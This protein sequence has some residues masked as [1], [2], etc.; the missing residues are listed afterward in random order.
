VST[1]VSV[2]APP[3]FVRCHLLRGGPSDRAV[4]LSA[5]ASLPRNKGGTVFVLADSRR[6][7]EQQATARSVPGAST[8]EPVELTDLIRFADNVGQPNAD[9]LALTIAFAADVMTGVQQTALRNRHGILSRGRSRSVASPAEGALLKL[10][11]YP[12]V[13]HIAN[14]LVALH[15]QSGVRSN[16]PAL[17]YSCLDA[18][19]RHVAAD[20]LILSEAARRVREKRRA[21]VCVAATRAVGSRFY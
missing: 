15:D 20:G 9:E 14:A 17:Y 6:P 21:E 16:R 18:L 7:D 8:D 5:A 11:T 1:S 4:K 19:Q 12:T 3:A 10:K 13:Q 2:D